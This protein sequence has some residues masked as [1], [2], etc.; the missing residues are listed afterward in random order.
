MP[1][2]GNPLF[3]NRLHLR[4]NR[5]AAFELHALGTSLHQAPR[6]P[7]R[8]FGRFIAP[9]G[10]IGYEQPFR[11]GPGHRTDVVDHVLHRDV[12]G[13]RKTQH[14]VAEGI[15]NQEN[16]HSGFIKQTGHG[17]IISRQSGDF[18]SPLFHIQN[19]FHCSP[20]TLGL[21]FIRFQDHDFFCTQRGP[22]LR[23][24]RAVS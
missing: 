19:F 15:P 12:G 17:V 20:G 16:I 14:H 2:N 5:P 24:S 4:Q 13:I 18:L 7:E 21:F 3:Q 10:H 9:V 8:F 6:V 23:M 1:A 11:M 22:C